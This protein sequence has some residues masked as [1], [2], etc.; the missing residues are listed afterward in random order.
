MHHTNIIVNHYYSLKTIQFF[1][2]LFNQYV[3][4]IGKLIFVHLV[5]QVKFDSQLN[6][7]TKMQSRLAHNFKVFFF[8]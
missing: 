2:F 4:N 1:N 3:L 6:A 5:N 7:T 8:F